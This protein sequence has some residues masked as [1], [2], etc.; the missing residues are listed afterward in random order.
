MA[1]ARARDPDRSSVL[2]NER[3][4]DREAK[5]DAAPD[6]AEGTEL[7]VDSYLEGDVED[8]QPANNGSWAVV[9]VAAP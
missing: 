8:E 5:A 4:T 3:V 1:D 7:R 2:L 6:W 9:R